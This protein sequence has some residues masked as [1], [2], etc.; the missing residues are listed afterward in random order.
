MEF[1][2]R[3]EDCKKLHE[4]AAAFEFTRRLK[5]LFDCLKSH[6][7]RHFRNNEAEHIAVRIEHV[8]HEVPFCTTDEV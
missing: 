6:R 8:R 4:S 2:S 3:Q 5:K 1:Y 7:P